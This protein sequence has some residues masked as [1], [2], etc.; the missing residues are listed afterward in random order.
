MHQIR[1]LKQSVDSSKKARSNN[2]MDMTQI[3]FTLHTKYT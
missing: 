1:T 3:E 2:K